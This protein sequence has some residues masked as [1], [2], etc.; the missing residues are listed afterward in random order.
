MNKSPP[1]H[2]LGQLLQCIAFPTQYLQLNAKNKNKIS[3]R[4]HACYI[5]NIKNIQKITLKVN[6]IFK[7]NKKCKK[8]ERRRLVKKEKQP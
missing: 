4:D 7:N 6:F 2:S 3:K 8:R 5:K 1:K